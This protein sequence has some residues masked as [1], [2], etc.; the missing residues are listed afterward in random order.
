[1]A[2]PLKRFLA[3]MPGS[4]LVALSQIE[5]EDENENG[6][7]LSADGWPITF[8]KRSQVVSCYGQP[9]VTFSSI[10]SVVLA[11]FTNGKRFE[12]WVLSL[13]L[14]GGK[15]LAIGRSTDGA[16]AS[17]VAAHVAT[18]TAKRVSAVK[19]VGL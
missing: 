5:I 3:L 8:D 11:H 2:F 7:V 12:W 16:Q 10:E 15:T 18:I 9:A 13:M 6:L 14:R 19:R 1:M 17:I 4:L